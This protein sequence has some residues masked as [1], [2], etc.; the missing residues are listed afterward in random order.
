MLHVAAKVAAE[1]RP[2]LPRL[3]GGACAVAMLA[4]TAG[5]QTPP[6]Q[7]PTQRPP[8]LRTPPLPPPPKAGPEMFGASAIDDLEDEEAVHFFARRPDGSLL[9]HVKG[10]R[11]LARAAAL[12][13]TPKAD[14]S[15]DIGAAPPARPSS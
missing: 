3:L 14:K 7:R 6:P 2:T 15:T 13:G 12:D 10:G 1:M 4:V 8:P 5:C 11:F 9:V